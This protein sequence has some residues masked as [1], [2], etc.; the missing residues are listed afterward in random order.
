[1]DVSS[2]NPKLIPQSRMQSIRMQSNESDGFIKKT[3]RGI[4][5]VSSVQMLRFCRDIAGESLVKEKF[6]H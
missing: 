6:L 2:G 3:K 1:M 5:T 4:D